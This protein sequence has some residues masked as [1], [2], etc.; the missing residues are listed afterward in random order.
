MTAAQHSDQMDQTRYLRPVLLLTLLS[1]L[2]GFATSSA[3]IT[4]AALRNN[5]SLLSGVL[6]VFAG[7]MTGL[8][9]SVKYDIK[10]E[11]FRGAAGQ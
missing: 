10:A 4:D 11:S 3:L 6:G 9:S 5:L 2:V 7:C 8:R 1:S